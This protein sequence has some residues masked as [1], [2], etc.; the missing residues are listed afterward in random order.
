[1]AIQR[2]NVPGIGRLPAFSHA[3]VVDRQVFLAGV[4]GAAGDLELVPGGIEPETR[5]VLGVIQQ[6][7]RA[8]GCGLADIAKV[9]VYL[10]DMT[11]FAAMNEVYME[12]MGDDPPP[13]ITIGC[14]ALAL[15]ALVEMDCVAFIPETDS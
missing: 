13:R 14:T 5:Q 12:V 7:L 6:V 4:I 10:T 9:N 2:V 1:M 15:G 3:S 11:L 8:C